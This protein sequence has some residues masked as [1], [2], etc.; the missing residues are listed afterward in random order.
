MSAVLSRVDAA[1]YI[2]VSVATLDRLRA[3]GLIRASQ[4][5]ARL[6]KYRAHDLDAYLTACQNI[7]SSSSRRLPTGISSGRSVDVPAAIRRAQQI[8]RKQRLSS[9]QRA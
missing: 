7:P 1:A 8:V 3:D 6:V 9:Q 4:V 5:S 2:G